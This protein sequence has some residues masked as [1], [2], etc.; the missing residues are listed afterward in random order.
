MLLWLMERIFFCGEKGGK[1]L[2]GYSSRDDYQRARGLQREGLAHPVG[3][4]DMDTAHLT[5]EELKSLCA[6]EGRTLTTVRE[7]DTHNVL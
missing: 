4:T 1:T 7:K 2:A 3:A 5:T 6:V